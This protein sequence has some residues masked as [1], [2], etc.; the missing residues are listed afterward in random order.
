M[1][2]LSAFEFLRRVAAKYSDVSD[3]RSISIFKV[4]ELDN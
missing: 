2:G 1:R 3:K 4:F